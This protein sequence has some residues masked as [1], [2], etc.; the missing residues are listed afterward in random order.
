MKFE[1]CIEKTLINII[2]LSAKTQSHSLEKVINLKSLLE[3]LF[4]I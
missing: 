4:R 1:I 2:F 3:F